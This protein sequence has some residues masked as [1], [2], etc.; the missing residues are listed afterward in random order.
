MIVRLVSATR[1]IPKKL[2]PLQGTMASHFQ[3]ILHV[4]SQTEMTPKTVTFFLPSTI[5]SSCG[6][7]IDQ[8]NSHSRIQFP[9]KLISNMGASQETVDE[10]ANL[11]RLERD[12]LMDIQDLPTSIYC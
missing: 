1:G 2:A 7:S 8:A 4:L 10:Q 12:K 5:D 9:Q 3:R 6:S 11:R